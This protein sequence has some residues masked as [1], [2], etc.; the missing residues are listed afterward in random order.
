MPAN[1]PYFYLDPATGKA[2]ARYP[3]GRVVALD[4]PEGAADAAASDRGSGG[5]G[6]AAPPPQPGPQPGAGGTPPD[7]GVRPPPGPAP[8]REQLSVPGGAAVGPFAHRSAEPPAPYGASSGGG[9]GGSGGSPLYQRMRAAAAAKGDAMASTLRGMAGGLGRS[10]AAPAP[11]SPARAGTAFGGTAVKEPRPEPMRGPYAKGLDPDQAMGL[12]LRPQ[13]MLPLAMKGLDPASPLYASLSALPAYPLAILSKRGYDGSPSDL[14]NAVGNFYEAVGERDKLPSFDTLFR[15]L[16]DPKR[17]GGIDDLFSGVEAT[18]GE[19]TAYGS[20]YA[21]GQEPLAM[22]EAAYQYQ[23][24]LDAIL[25][26]TLPAETA[27]KYSAYGGHLI[28]TA[29][30]KAMKRPAGKGKTINQIV[31]RKLLR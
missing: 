24:M 1:A 29:S 23:T 9:G 13:A 18:R 22:G 27:A 20:E 8:S 7:Y 26:A 25:G 2:M 21:Y 5:A 19:P 3:D 14:A 16:S 30:A 15:N 17:G 11:A 12:A 10:S 6:R 28:N 31:G 4:G